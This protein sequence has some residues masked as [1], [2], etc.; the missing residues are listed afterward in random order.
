MNIR[1]RS[2]LFREY[3]RVIDMCEGTI[4]H[5]NTCIKLDSK[6]VTDDRTLALNGSTERY[7]FAVAILEGKPVFVGDEVY[8][9]VTRIKRT[10]TGD[11]VLTDSFSQRFTWN[12]PKRTF[13]LAGYGLP[14][15]VMNEQNCPVV[16]VGSDRYYFNSIVERNEFQDK[17]NVIIQEAMNK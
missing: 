3:A 5:P 12:E 9:K 8:H 7:D 17:L 16:Y 1:K 14:L 11:S 15:P 4:L 13:T 2:D 10:I 6:V